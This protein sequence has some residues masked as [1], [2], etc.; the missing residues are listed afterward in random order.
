MQARQCA[1]CSRLKEAPCAP[2]WSM[3]AE[4]RQGSLLSQLRANRTA[5]TCAS[6]VAHARA[7]RKHNA[8]QQ[9]DSASCRM[10]GGQ[11]RLTHECQPTA[12]SD[13]GRQ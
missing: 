2:D 3:L 9:S 11:K 7:V 12:P 8:F 1:C 4:G 5:Q 10:E 13:R 6:T